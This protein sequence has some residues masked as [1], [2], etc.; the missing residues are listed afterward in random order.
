MEPYYLVVYSRVMIRWY[1]RFEE[2]LETVSFNIFPDD[3]GW[4]G[5]FSTIAFSREAA[6]N[7]VT[8]NS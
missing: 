8:N 5:S 7:F 6:Y 2:E 4:D 3:W 1:N